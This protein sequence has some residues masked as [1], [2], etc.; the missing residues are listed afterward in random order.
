MSKFLAQSIFS[1]RRL[2]SDTRINASNVSSFNRLLWLLFTQLCL[3]NSW[4]HVVVLAKLKLQSMPSRSCIVKSKLQGLLEFGSV[5]YSVKIGVQ[6]CFYLQIADIVFCDKQFL[7]KSSMWRVETLQSTILW[8][9]PKTKQKKIW[10]PKWHL[11]GVE[12]FNIEHWCRSLIWWEI[13]NLLR[14]SGASYSF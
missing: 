11:T 14:T 10:Q 1:I 8:S 12:D 9:A 2:H 6:L 5:C 3:K 13:L 4:S 7:E